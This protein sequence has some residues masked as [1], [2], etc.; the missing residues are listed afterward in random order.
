MKRIELSENINFE[1]LSLKTFH[2]LRY[3]QASKK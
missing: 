2:L 3:L 1:L